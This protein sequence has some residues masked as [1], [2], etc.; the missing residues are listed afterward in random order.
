MLWL[1]ISP[2]NDHYIPIDCF[3]VPR[4]FVNRH[5]R[6]GT[7]NWP[8]QK[9]VCRIFK[10]FRTLSRKYENILNRKIDQID[11]E[12]VLVFRTRTSGE[13]RSATTTVTPLIPNGTI[14]IRQQLVMYF[15]SLPLNG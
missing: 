4:L 2:Q 6:I 12:L 14:V 13:I 15:S 1:I 7:T 11:Q 5:L 8:A 10:I 3:P 9:I